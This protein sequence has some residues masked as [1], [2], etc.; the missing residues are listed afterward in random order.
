MKRILVALSIISALLLTGCSKMD[1]AASVGD[2]EITLAQ[3]QET[4]DSILAEREKVDTTQMQLEVGEDLARSQ[5]SF[6]IGNLII[7]EVAKDEGV[8]ISESELESYRLEVLQNIGGEAMLPS[9]LVNAT[10]APN[11]LIEVLRRDLILQGIS[12][13][14]RAAGTDDAGVND[15]I[16]R[17]VTEKAAATK[18]E[19]NPRYG[20]WDSASFGILPTDPTD[21]AVTGD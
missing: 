19:V 20:S 16:Q 18:I 13:K 15:L 8:V 9:V 12:A 17:L 3:L 21:G 1:L 7:E 10:I 2:N 11:S 4:V 14:A 5:L 6:L